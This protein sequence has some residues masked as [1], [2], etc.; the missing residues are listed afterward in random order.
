MITRVAPTGDDQHACRVFHHNHPRPMGVA[1]AVWITPMHAAAF[2][3]LLLL[4]G[5]GSEG[6]A[7]SDAFALRDSAGL[8]IA[9]SSGTAWGEGEAWRM[10]PERSEEDTSELQ[11]LM[12]TSY[13]VFCL[14]NTRTL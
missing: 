11:S 3:L 4:G 5:C 8:Q 10:S 14:K 7:R 2:S 12:R 9:E 1:G 13:A 6:V